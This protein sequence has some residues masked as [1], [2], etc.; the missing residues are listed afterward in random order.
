M[1]YEFTHLPQKIKSPELRK[2]IANDSKAFLAVI[3]DRLKYLWPTVQAIRGVNNLRSAKTN[4]EAFEL[5]I[6]AVFEKGVHIKIGY[7]DRTRTLDEVLRAA[8]VERGKDGLDSQLV[9]QYHGFTLSSTFTKAELI[10]QRTLA[11]LRYPAEW[12][13]STREIHRTVHLHVGPTNSGKTYHALKRLEQSKSGI[14][15]GPLR[16]L[17]HEVYTRLNAKGLPCWLITGEERRKPDPDSKPSLYSC[18]VEMVPTNQNV[19]VAVLDE[20]QM[21]GN[22]ER[23]WAWTQAFLGVMANEVHLCGEERTIPLIQ[24]LCAAIGDEL[25]IHRYERL[26]PLKMEQESLGGDWKKLRKGDAVICFS[27]LGIHSVKRQIEQVTGK[28]VAIVYGS[29]PPETRAQQA[30]LFNDPDNDYDILVASDAIGMGLN[31]Y[32]SPIVCKATN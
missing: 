8:F 13:P 9:Y 31:L 5:K 16:L 7:D 23:G 25:E 2:R 19:E 22:Q 20:I 10:S 4:W 3:R 32:G 11:D 12:F 28:K 30:R 26:S 24:E 29:L 27:V 21:I 17:A 6:R 18:T 14:Y 1:R 15:G